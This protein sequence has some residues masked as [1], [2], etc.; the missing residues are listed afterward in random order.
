MESSQI[1]TNAILVFAAVYLCVVVYR[2]HDMATRIAAAL[3]KR[4]GDQP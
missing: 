2:I 4:N 1:V 3:E